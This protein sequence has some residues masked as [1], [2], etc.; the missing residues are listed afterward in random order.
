ME[1]LKT[2]IEGGKVWFGISPP[3]QNRRKLKRFN[4][5]ESGGQ[6]IINWDLIL[7]WRTLGIKRINGV[8]AFLERE[9]LKRG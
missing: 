6:L 3:S 7:D 9:S 1:R 4:L 2:K 8:E 5:V